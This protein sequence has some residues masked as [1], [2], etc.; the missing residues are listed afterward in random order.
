MKRPLKAALA[1]ALHLRER[2]ESREAHHHRYQQPGTGR[3][4]GSRPARCGMD[5]CGLDPLR[6]EYGTGRA[7]RRRIDYRTPRPGDPCPGTP[8]APGTSGTSGTSGSGPAASDGPGEDTLFL[9]L[10]S[11][12]QFLT[13][14]QDAA[15]AGTPPA[16]PAP[17]PTAA[18]ERAE[19]ADHRGTLP[20]R[21]PG[22]AGGP[23]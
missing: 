13:A 10:K 8:G 22:P 9:F 19:D 12:H 18:V 14:P 1:D 21:T 5:P 2:K 15:T 3:G 17:G 20:R 11:L 7:D 4:T 6:A 23:P 16:G